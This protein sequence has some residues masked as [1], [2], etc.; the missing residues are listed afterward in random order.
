M[1]KI[2]PQLDEVRSESASTVVDKENAHLRKPEYKKKPPPRCIVSMS[3]E[4]RLRWDMFVI[5]LALY[6]CFGLPFEVAFTPDAENSALK[7]GFDFVVDLMFMIDIAIVFRTSYIKVETGETVNDPRVIAKEYL[8]DGRFAIDLVASIPVDL[9]LLLVKSDNSF[10]Q[11]IKLLK[12]VRIMR[13]SKIILAMRIKD[14]TKII[15]RICKLILYII[16][17]L[18]FLACIWFIVIVED[19]IWIPNT[20]S[21]LPEGSLFYDLSPVDQYGYCFYIAVNSLVGIEIMPQTTDERVFCLSTVFAGALFVSYILGEITDS[22][23]SLNEQMDIFYGNMEVANSVLKNLKIKEWL[24]LEVAEY[25]A[26]TFQYIVNYGEWT[27]FRN[28]VPP[29]YIKR[30]NQHLYANIIQE[31]ALLSRFNKIADAMVNK[32]EFLFIN[33]EER[34]MREGDHPDSFILVIDGKLSV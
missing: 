5:V 21:I 15:L 25:M 2:T 22:I 23:G 4:W 30:I 18:H 24:Q 33:P 1:V 9:V 10:I 32:L 16:I 31:Q 28:V 17:Y 14:R 27:R 13:L 20:D 19:E 12:L 26:S 3:N 6:N 7:L 8:M 29:R 11:L 34:L